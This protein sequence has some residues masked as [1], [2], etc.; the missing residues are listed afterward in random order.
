MRKDTKMKTRYREGHEAVE[1]KVLESLSAAEPQAL[2]NRFSTLV[3][4]SGKEDEFKA[5]QYISDRLKQ[6]GI[7]HQVYEPTLLISL[8][9]RS[10]LQVKE[11]NSWEEIRCTSPSF[12][13]STSPGWVEGQGAMTTSTVREEDDYVFDSAAVNRGAEVKGK[14]AFCEGTFSP[15]MVRDVEDMGAIGIV[16]IN[17]GDRIHESNCS[18]VWGTPTLENM[19]RLPGIPVVSIRRPDGDRLIKKLR[20]GGVGLRIRTE[21]DVGWRRCPMPVAE[22]RGADE[23]ESFILVHGHLD[24][25]YYGVCDNGT[26]NATLLELARV[27]HQARDGLGRSFRIAWNPGHSHGRYAGSTWYADQFAMELEEH[28]VAQMNIDSPGSKGATSYHRAAV[29]AELLSFA[30]ET[31]RDISGQKIQGSRPQRAGDY[32]FNNI[33]LTSIYMLLDEIPEEIRKQK[34]F[35]KVGGNGGN[36]ISWHSDQD[37]ME[38]IDIDLVM[39]HMKIYVATLCRLANA[40]LLP[41]DFRDTIATHQARLEYYQKV[42]GSRFDLSPALQGSK[43]LYQSLDKFYAS[44]ETALGS[45]STATVASMRRYNDVLLALGRNLIPIDYVNLARFEHDP[46]VP[47]PTLGRLEPI[48]DL[49]RLDSDPHIRN[50]TL[51]TLVHRRNQIVSVYLGLSKLLEKE[52]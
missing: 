37:L 39:K 29:M 36:S 27:L 35:Y 26:G 42:A 20:G 10:S 40:V 30:R 34:G 41:Y 7:S 32:S 31:I 24:G 52:S 48:Q 21:M 4:H 17:P 19:N 5:A 43:R 22:I 13:A 8:P 6:F 44:A 16:M 2:L 1:K 3:R 45:A 25:W 23:P 47:I 18:S 11:G 50:I 49:H 51:N 38:H 28:C 33:G 9:V 46:A 14:I 15:G 12:S